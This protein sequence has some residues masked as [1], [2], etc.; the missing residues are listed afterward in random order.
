M[1]STR[2]SSTKP[3]GVAC[4][5]STET[6]KIAL[7]ALARRGVHIQTATSTAA[8]KTVAGW[9][10]ATYRF[11]HAVGD[12]LLRRVDGESDPPELAA[13]LTAATRTHMRALA[14]LPRPASNHLD[15]R[16]GRVP[17]DQRRSQ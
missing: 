6:S 11:A 9:A 5:T 8:V 2:F 1:A 10:Y 3:R 12:G 16:L 14:T 15:A 17:A 4:V 7:T 13:R